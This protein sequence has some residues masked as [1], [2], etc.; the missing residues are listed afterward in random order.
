MIDFKIKS[1]LIY[2]FSKKRS[3]QTSSY[4]DFLL[5]QHPAD[6]LQTSPG[7]LAF[8]KQSSSAATTGGVGGGSNQQQQTPTKQPILVSSNNYTVSNYILLFCMGG[9]SEIKKNKTSN[10]FI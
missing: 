8:Q 2:F 3:F 9:G 7:G 10:Q 1:I 6:R 5:V 4:V